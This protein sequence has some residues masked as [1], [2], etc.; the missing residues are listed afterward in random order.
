M[1]LRN[2]KITSL[3]DLL[4]P[5]LLRI[6]QEYDFSI[7]GTCSKEFHIARKFVYD[8]CAITQTRILVQFY[9]FITIVDTKSMSIVEQIENIPPYS[10]K[11]VLQDYFLI[12][13]NEVC[14]LFDSVT[15]ECI[16]HFRLVSVYGEIYKLKKTKITLQFL[17]VPHSAECYIITIDVLNDS[18]IEFRKNRY[19]LLSECNLCE[20]F[21]V[22]NECFLLIADQKITTFTYNDVQKSIQVS[23]TCFIQGTVY[24]FAKISNGFIFGISYNLIIFKFKKII[25]EKIIQEF[26][27]ISTKPIRNLYLLSNSRLVCCSNEVF[28]FNL[29]TGQ[30]E[31]ALRNFMPN[32]DCCKLLPNEELVVSVEYGKYLEIY[33]TL[34]SEKL[35]TIHVKS[36][37]IVQMCT[38]H[39][40]DDVDTD[41]DREEYGKLETIGKFIVCQSKDGIKIFE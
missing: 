14:M 37:K 3:I 39:A 16:L 26:N 38:Q 40:E 32:R 6:V 8:I 15:C 29:I 22:S 2:L 31:S 24:S 30:R 27:D 13:N 5:D 9:D 4:P 1:T 36:N 7:M 20:S 25:Q 18:K 10:K 21:I 35:I 23:S 41:E 19:E 34:T 28:I 11:L 17:Y 12:K 33:N